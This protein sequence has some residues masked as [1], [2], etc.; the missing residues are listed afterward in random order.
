MIE[1]VDAV[2]SS[3]SIPSFIFDWVSALREKDATR[4]LD[5]ITGCFLYIMNCYNESKR[6]DSG[7]LNDDIAK[8]TL[9]G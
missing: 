1:D 5:F 9:N 3:F 6:S 7:H 8:G 2:S 4:C